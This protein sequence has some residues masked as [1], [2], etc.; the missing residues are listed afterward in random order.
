MKVKGIFGVAA[1]LSIVV[2][3]GHPWVVITAG[4]QESVVPDEGTVIQGNPPPPHCGPGENG[5]T[6]DG[7]GC[8]GGP[9]VRTL[10]NRTPE[11]AAQEREQEQAQRKAYCNAHPD[12]CNI[13]SR[14]HAYCVLHPD[15]CFPPMSAEQERNLIYPTHSDLEWTDENGK[16]WT[17]LTDPHTGQIIKDIT[18]TGPPAQIPPDQVNP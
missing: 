5:V 18:P 2:V 14:L 4:A 17:F 16:T 11:Q 15:R 12:D 6:K 1:A 10:P 13:G 8:L 7:K 9:I 3:L